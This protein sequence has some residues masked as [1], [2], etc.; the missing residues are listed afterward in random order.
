MSSPPGGFPPWLRSKRGVVGP[1]V[2]AAT[3]NPR[4]G[5]PA[6]LHL[7][8]E[9]SGFG[10]LQLGRSGP[11]LMATF[12]GSSQVSCCICSAPV[13]S[14]CEG[15]RFNS[16]SAVLPLSSP[17]QLSPFSRGEAVSHMVSASVSLPVG[18]ANAYGS[19]P[20]IV[21]PELNSELALKTG[22]AVKEIYGSEEAHKELKLRWANMPPEAMMCFQ[23][24]GVMDFAAFAAMPK[25]SLDTISACVSPGWRQD[26]RRIH[27]DA[28]QKPFRGL[29]MGDWVLRFSPHEKC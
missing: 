11:A 8:V 2:P 27:R 10:R 14:V 22:R 15:S 13:S 7:G 9:R 21:G 26:L 17:S 23:H 29:S 3:I 6:W 19:V 25:F 1:T 12:V 16:P 5:V 4:E 20:T 24:V 28:W 18:R